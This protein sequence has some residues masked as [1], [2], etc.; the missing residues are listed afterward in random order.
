MQ[1]I[2]NLEIAIKQHE[3]AIEAVQKELEEVG[4]MN[5]GLEEETNKLEVQI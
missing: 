5:I 1:E 2:L 3:A 4:N